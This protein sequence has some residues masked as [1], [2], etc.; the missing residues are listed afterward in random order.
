MATLA[1]E[2][3][4][5][6]PAERAARGVRAACDELERGGTVAVVLKS[7]ARNVAAGFDILTDDERLRVQRV[8][9]SIVEG[10]VQQRIDPRTGQPYVVPDRTKMVAAQML[11]IDVPRAAAE[12][13]DRAEK[14]QY[15]DPK[16]RAPAGAK[17]QASVEFILQNPDHPR[18]R[19]VVAALEE[20][21]KQ[22]G[23]EE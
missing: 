18:Y 12:A 14:V 23:S 6:N 5:L 2:V 8:L 7:L 15:L 1:D 11:L 19:E 20:N 16:N 17:I 21:Q 3:A 10:K 9:M 13:L 4:K 22:L